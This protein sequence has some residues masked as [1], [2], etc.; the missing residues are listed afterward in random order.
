VLVGVGGLV[1][2]AA[3]SLM[4][5]AVSPPASRPAGRSQVTPLSSGDLRARRTDAAEPIELY[6]K[7]CIECHDPDGRGESA[8]ETS[9]GAPDFTS[10]GWHRSRA[11][12]ELARVIWGGRKSMPAMKGKLTQT[13]VDRLVI[14]VRGFRDGRQRINE[15]NAGADIERSEPQADRL[16][17][18]AR[19]PDRQ[20]GPPREGE[21][22][23][24]GAAPVPVPAAFQQYCVR[25]HGISGDGASKRASFRSIPDFTSKAWQEQ[26]SESRLKLSIL[27]GKGSAMPPF[28]GR[29][30]E[31]V[32]TELV[33]FV[34][35]F[36]G[37]VPAERK[38]T[39]PGFD[40]RFQKLMR[41][42][43][44]LKRQYRMLHSAADSSADPRKDALTDRSTE[45]ATVR[46]ERMVRAAGKR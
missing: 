14:L 37:I 17:A 8:R 44:A 40:D 2:I 25:C 27:E 31:P 41:E 20:P 46:E 22:Q 21:T 43:E 15:E 4:A 3:S 34:R 19:P 29:I 38:S 18:S 16:T 10:A 35:S 45:P 1:V 13:N 28:S 39:G 23:P 5:Q 33:A 7:H 11:D 32:A 36:A 12:H 24:S 42:L 9:P 26:H 6:R 30:D